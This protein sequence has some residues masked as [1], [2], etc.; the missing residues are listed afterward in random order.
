MGPSKSRSRL[1][2]TRNGRSSQALIRVHG[3]SGSLTAH[4]SLANPAFFLDIFYLLR[5]FEKEGPFRGSLRF[6]QKTKVETCAYA[7]CPRHGNNRRQ[8]S[9]RRTSARLANIERRAF[10]NRALQHQFLSLRHPPWTVDQ[11]LEK[12]ESINTLPELN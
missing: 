1:C 6:A 9:L 11:L 4:R 2:S 8:G 5:H 3:S 10:L 12:L 7:S